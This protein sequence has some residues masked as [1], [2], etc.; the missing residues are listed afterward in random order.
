MIAI[1]DCKSFD[2]LTVNGT[3]VLEVIDSLTKCEGL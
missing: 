1:Y 3:A 2:I